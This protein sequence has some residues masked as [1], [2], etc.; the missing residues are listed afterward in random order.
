MEEKRD[1]VEA[2]VEEGAVMEGEEEGMVEEAGVEAEA[3]A[4]E[5]EVAVA[6]VMEG[7][8]ADTAA[9]VV[10]VEASNAIGV[11]SQ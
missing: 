3:M 6:A 2:T 11:Q 1:L 8:G 4:V 7:E 5:V 10:A 9:K